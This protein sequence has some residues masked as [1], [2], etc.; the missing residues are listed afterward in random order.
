[1]TLMLADAPW[2]LF[3]NAMFIHP[4]LAEGFSSLMASVE[5]A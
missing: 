2:T 4:T 1:M 5:A 3:E